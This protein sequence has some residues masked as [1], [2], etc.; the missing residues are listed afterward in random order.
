MCDACRR[1][2]VPPTPSPRRVSA[3][4]PADPFG[5][6]RTFDGN[7]FLRSWLDESQRT[8]RERQARE[9]ERAAA[10]AK[11]LEDLAAKAESLRIAREKVAGIEVGDLVKASAP[12]GDEVLTGRVR[13]TRQEDGL[14]LGT[15]VGSTLT[16]LARRG[17]TIAVLKK[18]L[19]TEE[20]VYR[21]SDRDLWKLEAGVWTYLGEETLDAS[22]V[23][24]YL[25]LVK[26]FPTTG[27]ISVVIEAELPAVEL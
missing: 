10:E 19:P 13:D 11:R 5:F 15:Q 26:I 14:T 6:T 8:A 18:A 25:P 12:E 24:E 20:G 4:V 17:W 9:A 1:L 2:T 27:E 22:E 23:E 21:D 7:A 3:T 16:A